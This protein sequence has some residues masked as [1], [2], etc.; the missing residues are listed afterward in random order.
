MMKPILDY[1]IVNGV[2]PE[3]DS[4]IRPAIVN[5]DLP[6]DLEQILKNAID[7]GLIAG[8]KETACASI[9]EGIAEQ[10]Y[11]ELTDGHSVQ[12]GDYFTIRLF[13][14]GQ[15]D[16]SG[17]LNDSANAINPRFQKG[18]EFDLAVSDFTM[19]YVDDGTRPV[20]KLVKSDGDDAANGRLTAGEDV[21]IF[22]SNLKPAE[23]QTLQVVFQREVEGEI[24]ETVVDEFETISTD[25]LKFAYPAIPATGTYKVFATFEDTETGR[26][27]PSTARN[28][29]AEEYTPAPQ[30]TITSVAQEGY[31]AGEID[32]SPT[33]PIVLTGQNLAN[34]QSV[35]I[36]GYPDGYDHDPDEDMELDQLE[37]IT[38]TDTTIS[39]LNAEN[40]AALPDGSFWGKPGRI[41]CT[42]ADGTTATADVTFHEYQ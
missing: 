36:L 20:I 28:V 42:W 38:S 1:N 27:Y 15:T 39:F 29:V 4:Y 24:E 17:T 16:G 34:V 14:D 25:L 12:F 18:S 3:G 26:V 40:T 37:D 23:G 9:A 13:L 8:L 19:H 10:M 6:N 21:L 11:K 41:V 35:K 31:E 22:G 5:R 30:H 2:T 33:K 32:F 7:R